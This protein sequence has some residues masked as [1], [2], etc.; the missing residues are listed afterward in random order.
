M[1]YPYILLSVRRSIPASRNKVIHKKGKW[2]RYIK[3]AFEKYYLARIR[4]DWPSLH[5]GW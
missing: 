3:L 4:H 1:I 2:A 5:F